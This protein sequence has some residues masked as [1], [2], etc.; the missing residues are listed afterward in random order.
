MKLLSGIPIENY[1]SEEIHKKE[2]ECFFKNSIQY[3]GASSMLKKDGDY[4]VVERLD[5]AK[6]LTRKNSDLYLLE[7]VCS[8]RQA[9]M[10]SGQGNS[11]NISCPLHNWSYNAEGKCV[12]TPFFDSCKDKFTLSKSNFENWNNLLFTGNSSFSNELKSFEL[13]NEMNLKKM[14]YTKTFTDKLNFNWKNYIDGFAEDYHVPFVHPGFA[15]F[16]DL[17][18][19][20]WIDHDQYTSQLFKLKDR[21][22]LEKQ[23]TTPKYKKWITEFLKFYPDKLP[24][25]GGILIMFYPNIMI[26]WYPLFMA[27]STVHP[28]GPETCINHIDFFHHEDVIENFP[29]LRDAAEAAYIETADEDSEMCLKLAAGRKI[30]Y[31]EGREEQGPYQSPYEDG[32]AMFH[33]YYHQ[34]MNL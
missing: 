12:N 28:T 30:L 7:N 15:G 19:I 33:R 34:K 9:K 13:V 10:V 3:I 20:S 21:S 14:V 24:Q 27:I 6:I 29:E 25:Y 23:Q 17:K 31:N 4:R 2:L 5:E 11:I 22:F 16:V 32:L 1:F 8:H 18:S 26:E